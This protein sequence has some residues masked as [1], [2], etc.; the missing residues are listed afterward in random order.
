MAHIASGPQQPLDEAPRLVGGEEEILAAIKPTDRPLTFRAD[1][2]IE[3]DEFDSLELKPFFRVHDAR[4]IIY[5]PL[6]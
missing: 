4:Y 5:W 6:E 3:P 2:A 1:A